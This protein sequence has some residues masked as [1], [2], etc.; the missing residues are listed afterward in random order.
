MGNEWGHPEWIDFPREGNG[1]SYQHARRLWSLVDD[2]NL[3]FKDLNA[4]DSAMVHFVREQRILES[5]PHVLLRDIERQL[6]AFERGGYLWVFNFSPSR[7]YT[8]YQFNVPAGKYT[9]VLNTDNVAFGG[10]GL[11]N[12]KY[13]AF[14]NLYGR[15]EPHLSLPSCSN[16]NGDEKRV[17]L[18]NKNR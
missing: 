4:F 18:I 16:R 10:A 9:A 13:R 14:Y 3:R 15:G 6:L 12:E 7:S 5:E 11:L 8:D 2:K 1:W 17:V